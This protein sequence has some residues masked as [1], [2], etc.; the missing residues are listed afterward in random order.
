M[1]TTLIVQKL[2]DY[3]RRT[4]LAWGDCLGQTCLIRL[5]DLESQW[6]DKSHSRLLSELSTTLTNRWKS[7]L[8][9][10]PR[11][12]RQIKLMKYMFRMGGALQ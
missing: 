10:D 3:S 2:E 9:G 7:V 8:V 1:R 12:K 5:C 6:S 4:G 11:L